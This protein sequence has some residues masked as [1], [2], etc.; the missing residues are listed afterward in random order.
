[1]RPNRLYEERSRRRWTQQE[2]AE[3]LRELAEH[4]G[5]NVGVDGNTWGR[6]ERGDIVPFP[7][8]PMLLAELFNSTP[9]ALGL[10]P[11]PSRRRSNAPSLVLPDEALEM[12]LYDWSDARSLDLIADALGSDDMDRRQFNVLTGALLTAPGLYWM[13]AQAEPAVA[14]AMEKGSVSETAVKQLETRLAVLRVLDDT[15][16]GTEL[17]VALRR[18]MYTTRTLIQQGSYSPGVEPRLYSVA[19]EVCRLAGY[20]A[21]DEGNHGKAQRYYITGLHAAKTAGNRLMG[22]NILGFLSMQAHSL[23][24]AQDA[25]ALAHTARLGVGSSQEVPANIR[26][27]L[28]MRAARAHALAHNEAACQRTLEEARQ[29]LEANDGPPAPEWSSWVNPGGLTADAGR[30]FMELGRP[31]IAEPLFAEA[32]KLYGDYQGRSR[33]LVLLRW[34]STHTAL[35]NL[36][37]AVRIGHEA[38]DIAEQV[39]SPRGRARVRD[40]YRQMQPHER[41]AQVR[42]FRDRSRELL[43]A[44]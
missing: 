32:A 39:D 36:D 23:G 35:K 38:L 3:R 4:C 15:Q 11:R 19:A 5:H 2:A 26:A 40:L 25:V 8:Y 13:T 14:A 37:E 43:K 30:C 34:A 31:D 20:L 12:L 24:N 33:M 21:F 42:E 22:A 29:A 27:M 17:R 16:G 18:L 41:V 44:A 9:E 7:P 10:D 6:W 28:A 1:M